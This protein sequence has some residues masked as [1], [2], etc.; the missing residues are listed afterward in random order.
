[1]IEAGEG[2]RPAGAALDAHAAGLD[3]HVRPLREDEDVE[4][5]D[6][7]FACVAR[8]QARQDR[9]AQL[10]GHDAEGRRYARLRDAHERL[11]KYHH[12]L[13]ARISLPSKAATEPA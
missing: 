1:L 10:G 6:H 3:S 4:D 11:K 9:I 13:M 12:T 7:L 2:L 8:H 5:H